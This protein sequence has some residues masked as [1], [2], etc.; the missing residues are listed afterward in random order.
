VAARGSHDHNLYRSEF[1]VPARGVKAATLFICGLGWS[2][3]LL[4]GQ[5]PTDAVL[6]TAPWRNNERSN[7]WCAFCARSGA[8][9]RQ[10]S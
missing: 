6:T 4:N 8:S 7:G 3:P 1:D 2:Q 10:R 9:K 5:A